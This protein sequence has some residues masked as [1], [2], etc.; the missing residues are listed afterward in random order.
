MPQLKKNT[1]PKKTPHNNPNKQQNK[2]Q[3]KQ[4][5]IVLFNNPTKKF[6]QLKE[7]PTVYNPLKTALSTRSPAKLSFL[8]F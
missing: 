6:T 1:P 2:H 8:F 4:T 5:E 3:T 7:I